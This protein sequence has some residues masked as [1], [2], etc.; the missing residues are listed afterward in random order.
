MVFCDVIFFIE[1]TSLPIDIVMDLFYAVADPVKTHI[2]CAGFT[3]PYIVIHNTVCCGIVCL[4]G[5]DFFWLVVTQ[6][7]QRGT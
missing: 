2:H 3:L 1:L 6:F 5:R 4:K 7:N